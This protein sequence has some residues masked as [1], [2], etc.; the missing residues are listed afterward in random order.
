VDHYGQWLGAIEGKD[1]TTAGF[2]YAGPL[3]EMLCLG[4]VAGQFPD[5]RL[6]W[7]AKKMKVTN[8]DAANPLLTG[9]YRK[10]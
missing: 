1:E 6:K 7:D 3:A 2:D 9:N 4:V 5:K 8:L 10:F